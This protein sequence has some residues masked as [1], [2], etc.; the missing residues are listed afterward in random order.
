MRFIRGSQQLA[1]WGVRL[2]IRETERRR[3]RRSIIDGTQEEEYHSDNEVGDGVETAGSSKDQRPTPRKTAKI[4][5]RPLPAQSPQ[6][7][8]DYRSSPSTSPTQTPQQRR[9]S[10]PSPTSALGYGR[11]R[12]P[13][14]GSEGDEDHEEEEP[15]RKTDPGNGPEMD[16]DEPST[17]THPDHLRSP[18]RSTTDSGL[19]AYQAFTYSSASATFDPAPS[20]LVH[21]Q[22]H[23]S[24]SPIQ[25]HYDYG[26][27]A[28]SAMHHTPF[29]HSGM[30]SSLN[31]ASPFEAPHDTPAGTA[32]FSRYG[33]STRKRDSDGGSSTTSRRSGGSLG[34]TGEFQGITPS[35]VYGASHGMSGGHPV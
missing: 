26:V 22:S 2:N 9:V 7:Q 20:P 13:R 5:P 11:H 4:K 25:T 30:R 12:R 24:T 14:R 1:R 6:S 10:S 31:N 32:A 15:P 17:Y 29:I 21:H 28:Q 8:I 35:F 3:R 33:S 19:P 27:S 16:C 34:S 23:S 18:S